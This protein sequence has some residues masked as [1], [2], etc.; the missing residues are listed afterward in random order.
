M[1]E[2]T[3][4]SIIVTICSIVILYSFFSMSSQEGRA[5]R[6]DEKAALQRIEESKMPLKIFGGIAFVSFVIWL[7]SSKK[8][9]P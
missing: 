5:L 3:L 7:A 8:K 2:F 4:K 9:N 6:P 1:K